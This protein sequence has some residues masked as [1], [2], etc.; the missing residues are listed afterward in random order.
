M[1]LSYA[2]LVFGRCFCDSS[3][4]SDPLGTKRDDGRWMMD[5]VDLEQSRLQL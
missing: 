5:D 3:Q 1:V 4:E 2:S